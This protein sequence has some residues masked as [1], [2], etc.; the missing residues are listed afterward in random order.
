MP[1]MNV[2]I[3]RVSVRHGSVPMDMDVRFAL[4]IARGV[5]VPMVLLVYVGMFV[6]ESFVDMFM[7]VMLSQVQIRSKHHQRRRNEQ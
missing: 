5:L 4:R 2:R 1:M 6:H 7:F 3:V